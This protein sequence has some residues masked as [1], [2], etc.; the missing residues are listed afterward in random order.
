MGNCFFFPC[1][2]SNVG[3]DFVMD[4]GMDPRNQTHSLNRKYLRNSFF[5]IILSFIPSFQAISSLK[6]SLLETCILRLSYATYAVF[7]SVHL[8]L[9]MNGGFH[10][11]HASLQ[12]VTSER[13]FLGFYGVFYDMRYIILSYRFDRL[14]NK[15]VYILLFMQNCDISF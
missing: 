4:Q 6:F 12:S 2:L 1:V 7:I 14:G 10:F 8:T 13:N 11:I 3:R 15:R 5:N 9:Y